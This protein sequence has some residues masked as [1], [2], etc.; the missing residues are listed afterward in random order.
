MWVEKKQLESNVEQVTSSKLR[1][2]Y[3]KAALCY[4]GCLAYAKYI[5]QNAELDEWQSGV[6]IA[7]RNNNLRYSDYITLITKMK[8]N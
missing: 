5:M 1:K 3:D 6:K 4:P 8:Q 2:K 7:G